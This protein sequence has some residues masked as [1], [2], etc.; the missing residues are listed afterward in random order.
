MKRDVENTWVVFESFLRSVTCEEKIDQTT[1]MTKADRDSRLTMVHIPIEDQNLLHLNVFAVDI[2]LI[3]RCINRLKPF[4]SD[5]HVVEEAE[6]HSLLRFGVMTRRTG[7]QEMSREQGE[8]NN[9]EFETYRTI[10]KPFRICPSATA[11]HISIT[12]PQLSRAAKAESGL[13]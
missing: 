9:V 11:L 13:T 4:R 10:A 8:A 7:Q 1:R 5:S 3:S 6:S 2:F 12:P